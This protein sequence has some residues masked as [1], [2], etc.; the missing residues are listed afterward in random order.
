MPVHTDQDRKERQHKVGQWRRERVK[1][2]GRSRRRTRA[3][4]SRHA[5]DATCLDLSAWRRA[6]SAMYLA[7]SALRHAAKSTSPSSGMATQ[8]RNRPGT[9]HRGWNGDRNGAAPRRLSCGIAGGQLPS[10]RANLD[11][12]RWQPI[13]RTWAPLGWRRSLRSRAVPASPPRRRQ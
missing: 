3:Q 1:T 4:G 8:G 5:G 7:V 12:P 10:R 11:H 2:D 6:G 13:T 9:W